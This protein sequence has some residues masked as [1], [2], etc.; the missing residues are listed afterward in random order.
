[1]NETTLNYGSDTLKLT[2]SQKLIGL[3]PRLGVE[4]SEIVL[5]LSTEFPNLQDMQETLGGFRLVNVHRDIEDT[6][7]T[8]DG[9]RQNNLIDVGTHVYHTSDDN[10]PF[11]PTGELYIVFDG[12]APIEDCQKLL[13]EHQ[14]EL[15]EARDER[16]IIVRVT[17]ASKNPIKTAV[18]LQ[19]SSLI[20]IAEPDLATPGMI[21]AF[22]FP[23]DPRLKDQWHLHN[24]G[25]HL[26][27]SLGL[28]AGADARLVGAW[29]IAQTLGNPDVVVAVIDDG[30]DLD[31]PD[32]AGIG[33]IA[34]PWDF[35]RNTNEPRPNP[36]PLQHD[37][38]DW[39]G[40]ACAGVAVGSA[41]GVGIVGAAPNCRIMPV[42][43]GINLSD[44]EIEKW[45]DYVTDQGAWV[46]SC[47]WKARANVFKLSDRKKRAIARC[48]REGRNGLGCVI[49]F[50]AGNDNRNINDP[51][52]TYVNGFALHPDV[53]PIAAS[54]SRDQRSHYSNFGEKIWVCAPSSGAG[55]LRITT[56]DV[57]GQY[58]SQFGQLREAGYSPGPYTDTF[59]GTSSACP[60]VAG[61]CALLLSIN[62][63]LKATEVKNILQQS[64][65]RIGNLASYDENG[66]S[67]NFG[68]GCV[69]AARAVESI[70]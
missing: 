69:D 27:T 43:W 28:L 42:R 3:R 4:D 59:G 24:T 14:L 26:G 8:L 20:S 54:T 66:H 23:L 30:F 44:S 37:L 35:T 34:A 12:D 15:I 48:A 52:G 58:L 9:A 46:V 49:C 13:E 56:A 10:V 2:K 60:L 31:H 53:I 29:D 5:S 22:S 39:H 50:A 18:A 11:I 19:Q 6:E 47:S 16:E 38:G 68:Y 55:G 21:A 40:T 61:V 51:D 70:L 33:K 17:S 41:N 25:S 36:R 57:T 1:M 64:A 7:N 32:L 45:F 67:I 62:P 63:D 65:R